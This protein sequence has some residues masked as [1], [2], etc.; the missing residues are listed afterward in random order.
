MET[1]N[2]TPIKPPTRSQMRRAIARKGLLLRDSAESENFTTLD[3][4]AGTAGV[5][6]ALDQL[7]GDNAAGRWLAING[8]LLLGRLP[9]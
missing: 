6:E 4:V 2:V 1:A 5:C 7:V 9:L 8:R 3:L